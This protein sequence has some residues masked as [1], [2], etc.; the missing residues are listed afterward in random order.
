MKSS[1]K[2]HFASS[3]EKIKAWDVSELDLDAD[4]SARDAQQE[5][6]LAL[7][8]ADEKTASRGRGGGSRS[9][10]HRAGTDLTLADWLPGE[11]DFR[12]SLDD[13]GEWTFVESPGEFFSGAPRSGGKGQPP[14]E[15][16]NVTVLEQARDR[17][18][19]ILR[20]ARSAAEQ[21][22]REAQA[23]I[24]QARRDGYQQGRNDAQNEIKE[25][26]NAVHAMV[27]ETR[28]W[29]SS[30]IEQ[31]E[32]FLA[33]M[34]K[35][36]AQ[37]MFGEGVQLDPHALQINLNRAMEHAQHLGDLNILLNPR[38]ARLLDPSWS[39]YQYLI[40][41]SKVRIVP[42]EKI[43]PGGCVV[44]GSTGMVDGRVE[45]QLTAVLNTL[46]DLMVVNG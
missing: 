21:V 12:S 26:L 43:A 37:T 1:P 25:T 9:N 6:I 19:E 28:A 30:L 29:Q 17:A 2:I 15:K 18:E 20:E 11:M 27:E 45:T 35:E 8:R 13:A 36:I 33:E 4:V 23:E 5:Q 7:F 16:E 46:D 41:G 40:T 44:K 38:D 39:E 34:L 22:V 32:R 14:R 31:G 42:S 24:E 10:L 3:F